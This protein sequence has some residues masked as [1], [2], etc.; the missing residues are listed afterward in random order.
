[1]SE[2][3]ENPDL[4]QRERAVEKPFVEK[5]DLARVEAVELPYGSDVALG[6]RSGR[7]ILPSAP[8]VDAWAP[9]PAMAGPAPDSDN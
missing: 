5:A 6:T 8:V 9:R 2:L 4:A 1:M 3:V 7:G